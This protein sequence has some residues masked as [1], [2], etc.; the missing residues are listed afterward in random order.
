MIATQSSA[1]AAQNELGNGGARLRRALIP[2]FP[3]PSLIFHCSA[4]LNAGPL[5]NSGRACH[6]FSSF[7]PYSTVSTKKFIKP[8]PLTNHQFIGQIC[9]NIPK[10]SPKNMQISRLN[11]TLT[12]SHQPMVDPMPARVSRPLF[13]RRSHSSRPSHSCALISRNGRAMLKST[14]HHTFVMDYQ[15]QKNGW[16]TFFEH[17]GFLLTALF[18]IAVSA[19]FIFFLNLTG[20]S[21]IYCFAADMV[22]LLSGAAMILYAKIPVYRSGHFFTFGIKSVPARLA[23]Y[24]RW[25]WR[26]FLSG[27]LLSLCLLL[28]RQ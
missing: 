27:V 9:K 1:L 15:K 3:F 8:L 17:W 26:V 21:W 22:I 13:L 23:G 14:R 19:T 5:A 4:N 10:S 6:L 11:Q 12:I 24:Y 25:G 16:Q 7:L 20:T 2:L 18:I 28:S